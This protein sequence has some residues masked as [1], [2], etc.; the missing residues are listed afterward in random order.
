MDYYKLA[1]MNIAKYGDTDIFPYPI[2]NALF[3]DNPEKVSSILSD[4]DSNFD[5]WL[6]KYPVECI[7]TCIPVGYTG[8]RWGTI[9]DPIWNS[10]LLYLVLR[11]SEN[12]ENKRLSQEKKSVFSYRVKL[13]EE[14]GKI[15][16][17]EVNWRLF[18][19]TA[20][21]IASNENY[22]YVVRLD[23][24][25]FYNRIYHHRLENALLRSDIDS[26]I[27]YKITK[28][29]Q[30]ISINASYGLPIGGNASRIL[31]EIL[32]NSI[33]QQMNSKRIRFCRFV[34]DFI[35][36]ARSREE[37]FSILNWCADFLLRNEGLSLQKSKTQI[38]TTQEFLAHAKSIIY[39]EEGDESK[40]RAEFLKLHLHYD[41]YSATAS[42]DYSELKNNLE[43]FDIL[44][45]IKQEI[46]KSHIHQA[47]SKQLMNSI[48]YLEGEKLDLAFSAIGSNLE[49]LYP[50]FPSVMQVAHSKLPETSSETQNQFLD[51]LCKLVENESYLVQTDN[52]AAYVS[53]VLS[54]INS[55]RSIQA[56]EQLYSKS[57]S[58]LVKTN[59]MYSMVNLNNHYWISDLRSK[60]SI[61][62]KWE[63][64]AYIAAS[65]YLRDEGKHWRKHTKEQFSALEHIVLEWVS[66]KNPY[67]NNWKLPL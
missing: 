67:Q 7:K 2:E 32:L 6:S 13:D 57:S 16:N 66:S 35:I 45:L 5:N 50:I 22:S 17:P 11:I 15:F 46:R 36:F 28:I 54:V 9:I 3:Y 65:Y 64:R 53:R 56:I 51:E 48:R 21:D 37:A 60:F 23:I 4:I 8:F 42:E 29:L 41:P 39:G 40:E 10:Y 44:S 38:Q 62:S 14:T 1:V 19:Q 33:D 18:Y 20:M 12:L 25:D 27:K 26:E 34:D 58:T 47:L 55:D 59:C 31:A 30:D 52:N 61:M 43:Q 24:S 63:R 49:T